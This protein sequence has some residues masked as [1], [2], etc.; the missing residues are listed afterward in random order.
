[1]TGYR[2]E[3]CCAAVPTGITGNSL[4]D[5]EHRERA[6]AAASADAASDGGN[7]GRRAAAA[8]WRKVCAE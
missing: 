2:R 1:M 7:V 3:W 4:E 8:E 5:R 6:E